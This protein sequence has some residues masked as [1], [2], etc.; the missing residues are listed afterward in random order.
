MSFN[1]K[2]I[3][4][5]VQEGRINDDKFEPTKQTLLERC[6]TWSK[7]IYVRHINKCVGEICGPTITNL[8]DD[9]VNFLVLRGGGM[10][11]IE[12]KFIGCH[13]RE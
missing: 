8:C 2:Y 7:N 4:L 11:M 12:E 9:H 5:P 10:K 13:E 3:G 6:S 1:E